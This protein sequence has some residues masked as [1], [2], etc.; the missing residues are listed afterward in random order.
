MDWSGLERDKL[1]LCGRGVE[2][3]DSSYLSGLDNPQDGRAYTYTDLDHD[4]AMD[5][6]VLNRNA[7]ILQIYRNKIPQGNW[8]TFQLS[9]DARRSDPEAVGALVTATCGDHKVT[10]CLDLGSGF[11]VQ[12]T[13]NLQIGLDSCKMAEKLTVRW[14]GGKEQAFE[15][16]KAGEFYRLKEGGDLQR[17]HDYYTPAPASPEPTSP[18]SSH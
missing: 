16:V 9:G 14:P 15:N 2:Y 1:F 6:I 8:I 11:G 17:V 12:N 18:Q 10:R 7:P 4:G 5:V 13:M 3:Q